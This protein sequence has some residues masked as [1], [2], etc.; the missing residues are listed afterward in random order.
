MLKRRIEIQCVVCGKPYIKEQE[1]APHEAMQ[2]VRDPIPKGWAA[3][4][5]HIPEP[6]ISP[7]VERMLDSLL[8]SLRNSPHA[9]SLLEFLRESAPSYVGW[10]PVCQECQTGPFWDKVKESFT[11]AVEKQV[12]PG[13]SLGGLEPL[14]FAVLPGGAIARPGETK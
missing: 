10:F 5:V 4:T 9:D 2:D 1:I 6:V 12:V 8:S 3:L 7:A 11:Q 14:P 13:F